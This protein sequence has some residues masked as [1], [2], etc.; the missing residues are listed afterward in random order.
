VVYLSLYPWFITHFIWREYYDGVWFGLFMALAAI[1][2]GFHTIVSAMVVGA[3]RAEIETFSRIMMMVIMIGVGVILIPAHGV[4]GTAIT[5]FAAVAGSL[6][7]YYAL[8]LYRS[9]QE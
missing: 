4:L 5:S 9:R 7:S 3:E 2:Y 6:V 8:L 1:L